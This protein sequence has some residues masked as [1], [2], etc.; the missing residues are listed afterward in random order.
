[1]P[2]LTRVAQDI[3]HAWHDDRRSELLRL[4]TKVGAI[5]AGR[6]AAAGDGGVLH[7]RL[8]RQGADRHRPAARAG[9]SAASSLTATL[10]SSLC[11][12]CCPRRSHAH[13]AVS[14]ATAREMAIGALETLGGHVAVAVTG[15]AGPDGAQPGKPVGHGVVRLGVARGGEIETRVALETFSGDR[16]AVRRQ[17]VA[18]A[19][20]RD[21]CD[22]GQAAAG[23][24][25]LRNRRLF[26]A[27]WPTDAVRAQ[28]G[29]RRAEPHAALRARDRRPQS[30]RHRRFSRRGSRRSASTRVLEAAQLDAEVD[31]RWQV[32]AAS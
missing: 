28:L 15:I 13:G 29:R 9:F 7:R 23:S 31:I 20:A 14:E 30:A 10:S 25:R 24:A 4:A 16:E 19:L 12:A 22:S 27:L 21:C 1:M 26:F 18:R 11:S 17:T 6:R 32:Y 3:K 5:A 8:D 2:S